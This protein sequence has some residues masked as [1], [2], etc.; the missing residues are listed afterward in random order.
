MY[1]ISNRN[2]EFL[3][4][5]NRS[6]IRYL[7]VSIGAEHLSRS[8]RI[9]G[10]PAPDRV[11][12]KNASCNLLPFTNHYYNRA[13][14]ETGELVIGKSDTELVVLARGGDKDSFGYL[15]RRYQETAL[16]FAVRLIRD[17]DAAED[18]AQEAAVQAWRSIG[19]LRDPERFRSWFLGIV[20]NVCRSDIRRRSS[21]RK[22]IAAETTGDILSDLSDSPSAKAAEELEQ[23]Q[24]VTEAMDSLT[25]LYKEI[26]L[27]FYF[28]Q[29]KIPE[30]A[31]RLAVST[32]TVK[33]RLNR[34]RKQLRN[35]LLQRNPELLR[36]MGGS[37]MIKVVVADIIR[38]ENKDDV[39]N[40]VTNYAVVLKEEAGK[41]AFP[42]WIGASES[43]AIAMGLGKFPV[44]RPMTYDFFAS[45]LKAIGAQILEVR[46]EA[47]RD[48]TFYGI[49]KVQVGDTTAE[50]DARP[51]DALAL[52]ISTGS[53]VFAAEEVMEKA[54]FEIPSQAKQSEVRTGMADILDD[55]RRMQTR[56]LKTL[57]KEDVTGTDSRG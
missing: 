25:S 41:R 43:A 40:P 26:I 2:C 50:V 8:R 11:W 54:G 5:G 12:P 22:A 51:S 19:S 55:L 32:T 15:V 14:L 7:Q 10:Q 39:G 48:T 17:R 31:A 42:M 56:Q 45:I 29:L 49:V 27:L 52:A 47:L 3:G 34:A 28:E 36:S 18:L 4:A 35:M 13:H 30:I 16:R 37:T 33:V 21:A 57:A 1:G 20:W 38:R 44:K 53:P 6:P 23:R 24:I 46:V 9:S